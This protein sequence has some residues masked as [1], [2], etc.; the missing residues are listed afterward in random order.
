LFYISKYFIYIF[1]FFIY[2]DK[3]SLKHISEENMG[4]S[5]RPLFRL[6]LE[7]GMK[8]TDLL[9]EVGISSATLAKLSKGEHLSAE[10]IEK[11]CI[12]FHCQPGDLVEY[13]FNGEN[14][15]GANTGKNGS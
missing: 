13:T 14:E 7:R 4:F 6:R 2:D 5:Y 15:R 3:I 11:I 1:T 12:F 8:K 10:S 9:K